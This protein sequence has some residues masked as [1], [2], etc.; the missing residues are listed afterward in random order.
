MADRIFVVN[1]SIT[2]TFQDMTG[3]VILYNVL[4]QSVRNLHL[5]T[6]NVPIAMSDLPSSQ[7]TGW[8]GMWKCNRQIYLAN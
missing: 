7:Y 4:G 6:P 2:V 1:T 3:Q 5:S 8:T